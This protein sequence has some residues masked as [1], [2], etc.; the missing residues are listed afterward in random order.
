MPDRPY[1]LWLLNRFGLQID[2]GCLIDLKITYQDL[3]DVSGLGRVTVT[4]LL[5]QFKD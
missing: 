4:R 1:R 5:R 3:A 2:Q